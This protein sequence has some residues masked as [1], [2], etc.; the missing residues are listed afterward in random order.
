M[1]ERPPDRTRPSTRREWH[2]LPADPDPERD[3]KYD[4]RDWKVI[5]TRTN[6]RRRL[7]F[8]PE[9]EERLRDDAFVVA[10][11]QSVCDVEEWA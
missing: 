1:G 10:D 11:G 7:M 5:T 2:R 4:V 3:L 9:N 8:L 6:G